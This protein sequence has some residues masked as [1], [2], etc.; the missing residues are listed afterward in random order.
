MDSHGGWIASAIDMARFVRAV[1]G[2]GHGPQIL[3]PQSIQRMIAHPAP[4]VWKPGDATWYG[5]GWQVRPTNGD[6]NWWHTGSLDGTSTL[7]VR[8]YNGLTWVAFFNCRP[9]DSDGFDGELDSAM[10][11]AV[12]GVT[13][14]PGHDLFP[15]AQGR[16]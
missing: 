6:A 7:M 5:M 9:K 1:D 12:G 4:P 13:R 2:W 3:R 8:T 15:A 10:W 11:Q 16:G 14:W